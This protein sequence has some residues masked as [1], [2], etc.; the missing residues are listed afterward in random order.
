MIVTC[1]FFFIAIVAIATS[2][3]VTKSKP[4]EWK[5]AET[6]R[7]LAHE[8]IFGTIATISLHLNGA[9]FAQPKSFVDGT[10][11]NS[12]GVLYFYDSDMDTS[13]QD[14]QANN[15]VSFALTEATLLGHC[16]AKIRDPESPVCARVTFNGKF[17]PVEDE[18]EIAFAKE[19]LFERHPSMAT[20]PEEHEFRVHKI[21]LS[22]IWLIDVYGGA[23]VISIE[24]YYSVTVN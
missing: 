12:T 7:W 18:D 6:A 15:F 24:D 23:S 8:N 1:A 17:I 2:T 5:K 14:I 13:I 4:L 22:D 10:I 11:A 19:A 9:P 16:N 3:D 21:E 20:W